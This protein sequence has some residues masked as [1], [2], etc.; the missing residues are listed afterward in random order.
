MVSTVAGL[1]VFALVLAAVSAYVVV[2]VRQGGRLRWWSQAPNS[3]G[4]KMDGIGNIDVNMLMATIERYSAEYVKHERDLM[5]E[6]VAFLG[7]SEY[8]PSARQRRL[9]KGL[10]KLIMEKQALL[11]LLETIDSDEERYRQLGLSP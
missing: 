3:Q 2:A 5:K 9:V 4:F 8:P 6:F 1:V 10:N 11:D 7:E